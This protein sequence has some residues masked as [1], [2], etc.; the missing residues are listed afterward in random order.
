MKG[1]EVLLLT[2]CILVPFLAGFIGSAFTFSEIPTWYASLNK[3]WFNPPNWLFAPAWTTLY[4]LIGV[5]LFLVVRNGLEKEPVKSALMFFIA[6]IALNALWSIM[7]FG[8]KELL[9]AFIE[10]VFLWI[11]ILANIITAYRVDKKAGYIL[12]PYI[13]WVTFAGTLNLFVWLLNP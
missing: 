5:S 10:L 2:V 9:L 13:C 4:I 3:P 8:L 6:Q 12:I 7:F 11:F 1:K